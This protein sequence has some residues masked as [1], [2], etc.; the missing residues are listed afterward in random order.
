MSAKKF[1]FV[2]QS[3]SAGG[4]MSLGSLGKIELSISLRKTPGDT[5]LNFFA[6]I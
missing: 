6:L 2:S 5:N 1:K 3:R 4:P